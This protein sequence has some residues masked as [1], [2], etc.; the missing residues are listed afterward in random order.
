MRGIA[1]SQPASVPLLFTPHA[2]CPPPPDLHGNANCP[3]KLQGALV[4]HHNVSFAGRMAA[5]RGGQA[6]DLQSHLMASFARLDVPAIMHKV[7]S[8]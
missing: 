1:A 6:H 8:V 2:F 3:S 5:A 4:V 7:R